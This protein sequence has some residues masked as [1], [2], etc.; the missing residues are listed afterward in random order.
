MTDNS[1]WQR[2]K[3]K[4]FAA[5][6]AGGRMDVS[7]LEKIVEIGCGDGVF[8]EN[9]KTVLINIIFNMTRAD[10]DDAMW[11][12]V[13]ELI[14]KFE[15]HHDNDAVIEEFVDEQDLETG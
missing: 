2:M 15:L 5:F 14:N 10:L 13:D 7:E 3:E 9:E 1:D 11:A 6:T 8:D 4:A 12:K